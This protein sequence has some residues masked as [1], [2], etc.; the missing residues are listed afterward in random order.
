MT[1]TFVASLL[2][3]ALTLM[4]MPVSGNA[5]DNDYFFA[6]Q[7]PYEIAQAGEDEWGTSPSVGSFSMNPEGYKSPSRAIL[8]SLLLPGLGE[9]YVGDS[10]TKATI[11]LAAEAGI[12][13]SFVAFRLQGGWKKDDYKEFAVV[14][15]GIDP[16]GKNDFFWDII[17]FHASRQDYNKLSRVYTRTNP[18]YP[19]TPEWDWQWSSS[20]DQREYRDI[21]NDSKS[22]YRRANFALGAAAVNRLISMFY[23]WRSAKGHNRDLIDEFSKLRFEAHPDAYSNDIEFR[24]EYTHSF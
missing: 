24:L 20:E 13:S 11:F 9:I 7:Q 18:Y 8:Y 2:I 23:A 19:D 4:I 1:R 10:R 15:A 17:G 5:G 14:N 21:K 3:L 22:S 12:W 16:E 6:S